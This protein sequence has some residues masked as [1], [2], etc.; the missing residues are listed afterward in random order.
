LISNVL[1]NQLS[2]QLMM[3]VHGSQSV[4]IAGR[5]IHDNFRFV[6][7]AA[8]L[9]H[10]QNRACVLLKIDIMKAFYLVSWSF[11]LEI[12]HLVGFP[13][14]W[15]NW[16]AA[17]LYSTSTKIIFNG[18]PGD[19]I[20]HYRGLCQGDPL[21]PMLF[22]L[23][24]EVLS[25]LIHKTDEFSMLQALGANVIPHWASLYADDLILFA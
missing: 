15:R 17:L 3:L 8:R 10:S 4:F 7:S 5:Y 16:V 25:A 14:A 24:M 20:I 18:S 21:S 6:W 9:L 23:V 13:V 2:P 22:L 1:A 12:L 11:L 19:S